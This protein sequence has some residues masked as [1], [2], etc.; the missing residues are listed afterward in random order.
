MDQSTAEKIKES[1][2][3]QLLVSKRSTY[4]CTMAIIMI[5]VYFV[6]ISLIAFDPHALAAKISDSSVMSIG[7]VMGF[8]II[9]FSFALTGLYVR[10]ANNEFDVLTKKIQDAHQ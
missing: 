4:N 8:V 3:F 1:A 9:I 2:A 10:R 5:V 6:F 7:I